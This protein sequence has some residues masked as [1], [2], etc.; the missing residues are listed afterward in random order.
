M[1]LKMNIYLRVFGIIFMVLYLVN[2]L[3]ELHNKYFSLFGLCGFSILIY[4]TI[5]TDQNKKKNI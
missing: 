1:K 3:F 4:S 2:D 5:R